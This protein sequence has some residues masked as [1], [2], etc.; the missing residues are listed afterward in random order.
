MPKYRKILAVT[1]SAPNRLSHIV[2]AL[3]ATK[4]LDVRVI[5]QFK[6]K[7]ARGVFFKISEKLRLPFDIDCVNARI[8]EENR[9]FQPDVL[10]IIKGN[11]VFPSTLRQIRLDNPG[12]K[13]VSWSQDDMYAIHNR[14]IYY[15]NGLREY[16]LVVTQ[17]SFNLG[18]LPSLGAR[19]L[20]FQKKAYSEFVHKPNSCLDYASYVS[21]VSFIG[22]A[23]KERFESLQFLARNGIVVRVFGYGWENAIYREAHPNLKIE[24]TELI[25]EDYSRM[26]SLT[27]VNLCFLRKMNRDLHTSRSIEIPA[28]NGFLLAEMSSEHSEIFREDIDAAFF[29]SDEELLSKVRYYLRYD[30]VRERISRNGYQRINTGNY[31]YH[32]RLSEIM[33]SL[34]ES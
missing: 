11:I 4:G 15:T 8:R 7:R 2:E 24:F 22:S 1:N 12:V 25:G 14:S 23:E 21:D 28:C 31:S 16:D 18:E 30:S 34:D 33:E 5:H 19:K 27:K 20:L 17:K 26:I 29:S 9:V 10:F 3:C 32:D 13:L 6:K